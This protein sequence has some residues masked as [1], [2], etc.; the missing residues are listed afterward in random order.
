MM[1]LP[2]TILFS[3]KWSTNYLLNNVY[4]INWICWVRPQTRYRKKKI[5]NYILPIR[6][7]IAMQP[8]IDYC[9]KILLVV[10]N[11]FKFYT[12]ELCITV[13]STLCI[14]FKSIK[15]RVTAELCFAEYRFTD[16]SSYLVS[17]RN[18]LILSRE[19]QQQM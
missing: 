7:L 9:P 12:L 8:L 11:I 18:S 15:D 10:I 5:K 2:T 13:R 17:E 19:F 1:K 4:D 6:S 3:M 14:I 16:R